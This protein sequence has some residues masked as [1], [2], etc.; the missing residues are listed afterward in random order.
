M[1]KKTLPITNL[2]NHIATNMFDV[3]RII[4]SKQQILSVRSS[5][6]PTIF[7]KLQSDPVLTRPKL[8]S[9]LI[10]AH[11]C[12]IASVLTLHC[13]QFVSE[14]SPERRQQ[15]GFTFV[16]GGLTFKFDKNSTNL[17]CFIFRFGGAWSYVWGAKPTKAPHGDRTGLYHDLDLKIQFTLV[18]SKDA[19]KRR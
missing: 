11:L 19:I 5:P 3:V 7:K 12:G 13:I 16:R 18:P 8:A 1:A 17:Y 10:R 6:D 9:V 4:T 2:Q 15:G 14:P